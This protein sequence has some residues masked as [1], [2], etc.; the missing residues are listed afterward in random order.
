MTFII[1]SYKY[2]HEVLYLH[3][4]FMSAIWKWSLSNHKLYD[5]QIEWKIAV[6][7]CLPYYQWKHLKSS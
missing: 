2:K 5:I 1:L 6:T 7:H 3:D 4:K